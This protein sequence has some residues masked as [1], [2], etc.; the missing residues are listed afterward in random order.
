LQ[1]TRPLRLATTY[2]RMA[3]TQLSMTTIC[4]RKFKLKQL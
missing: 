4:G 2:R 1:I 3:A